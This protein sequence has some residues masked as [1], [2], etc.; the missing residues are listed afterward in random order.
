MEV[1]GVYARAEGW[2]LVLGGSKRE[3]VKMR[4]RRV[5]YWWVVRGI[6][7]LVFGGCKI[8]RNGDVE[9]GGSRSWVGTGMLETGVV[10]E[11]GTVGGI[12][13]DVPRRYHLRTSLTLAMT[14]SSVGF[15]E[16]VKARTCQRIS[17]SS[18][19]VSVFWTTQCPSDFS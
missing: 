12:G 8:A 17:S 14:A 4:R 7:R 10:D 5:L 13:G 2:V 15:L 6:G 18:V 9:F 16:K 11:T 19:K 1:V 3:M